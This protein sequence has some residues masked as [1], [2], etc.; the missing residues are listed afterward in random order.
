MAARLYLLKGRLNLTA[1]TTKHRGIATTPRVADSQE[2]D[3]KVPITTQEVGPTID[4]ETG[5]GEIRVDSITVRTNENVGLVSGILEDHITSRT[6]RIY[7][8]AK[9]AMQSGTNNTNYWQIDFDT[10]QRWENPLIGWTSTGDPMS[11]LKVDFACMEDAIE[12]CEK[13]GWKY[14]VQKPNRNSPKPRS[15]GVNFAWNRRTRVSTK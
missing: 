14:Y 5:L 12:H 6:V 9:N 3:K 8:P 4:D 11:N 7:Q 13:M 15:Y 10:R 2:N 1:L